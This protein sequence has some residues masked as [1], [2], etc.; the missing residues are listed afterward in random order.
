MHD[1]FECKT[2]C[3]RRVENLHRRA[4][5]SP[6]LSCCGG[7]WDNDGYSSQKIVIFFSCSCWYPRAYGHGCMDETATSH[8]HV[9]T[10][11]KITL[12]IG[13]VWIQWGLNAGL[14]HALL[15]AHPCV[16]QKGWSCNTGMEMACFSHAKCS[17]GLERAGQARKG[18]MGGAASGLC[19]EFSNLTGEKTQTG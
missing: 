8:S 6:A 7:S 5:R 13:S 10:R 15:A 12:I 14:Q 1:K 9:E 4:G 11:G 16:P 17:A 19:S 18:G 2:S 3:H